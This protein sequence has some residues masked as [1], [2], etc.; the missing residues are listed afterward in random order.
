M[1]TDTQPRSASAQCNA[2][3]GFTL[4]ELMVVLII[5]SIV[6][7][8]ALPAIADGWDQFMLRRI[9]A[10][11]L[12]TISVA[13]QHAIADERAT[14]VKFEHDA[15]CI[16]YQDEPEQACSLGRGSLPPRYSFNHNL[17]SQ[18]QL[19]YSAGRGFSPLSA[20]AI[21]LYSRPGLRHVQFINSSVGRIR[22]CSGQ[23]IPGIPSC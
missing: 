2:K 19:L 3:R 18:F 12:A 10:K 5:I 22:L 21:R 7:G 1:G 13:R 6:G 15:W 17:G 4:I 9:A 11:V 16:Q 8:K 14:L 20:G 23:R